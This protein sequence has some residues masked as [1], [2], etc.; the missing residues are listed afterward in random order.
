M[1]EALRLFE[2]PADHVACAT[3]FLAAA[4][5]GTLRIVGDAERDYEHQ[6]HQ[7]HQTQVAL[8]E[9]LHEQAAVCVD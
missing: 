3:G 7:T 6:A 9:S 8:A 2:G 4:T 1:T 5:I